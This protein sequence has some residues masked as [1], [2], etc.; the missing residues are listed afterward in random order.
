MINNRFTQYL[1]AELWRA[2]YKARSGKR[3][4]MD[5]HR[6]ELQAALNLD[7][8][9][10]SLLAREYR[11]SRGVAFIIHDPVMRE[12]VAAP[13]RD[14][15]IH[16]FLYNMCAEW[17]D[18]HFIY[19]S[20]SCRIGKGTL[21]GQKRLAHH[22]AAVTQGN[23]RRAFVAKLDIQGY[24]M[25]LNHELLFERVLW[26][27]RQQFYH[28]RD[29]CLTCDPRDRDELY[30]LLKYLWH[31]VIFDEPMKNV[32]TRGRRSNWKGL[33][34]NK[35]LF[36]QPPEQGIVIGN[37]TSQLLSNIFLDQLDRYVTHTLGYK[38][39]GRYVD[40]FYIVVP[41]SQRQ[42]LVQDVD[43]IAKFLESDLK[44]H[45]HPKKRYFQYADRGIPFIGAVVYP[46][47]I[48]PSRR[49]KR[50]FHQAAYRLATQGK[51][52]IESVTARLGGL[53][54]INH[55]RFFKR[56][57][58]TYGWDYGWLSKEAYRQKRGQKN[59]TKSNQEYSQKCGE[60]SPQQK[61]REQKPRDKQPPQSGQGY[62]Q[63]SLW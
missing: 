52:D 46:G 12:I 3:R 15:V 11:P 23:M 20:Y 37:L 1:T 63:L 54:H 36:F 44:L 26:G 47:R 38:H 29:N 53:E 32:T 25:S 49:A 27:L 51:G 31:Q 56:A 55:R 10:Q 33:P 48:L 43:R 60:K 21:F 57:F 62:T 7:I 50:N 6:F 41:E 2:Y 24:F 5:E 18:R 19:D 42:Q 34:R 4:T 40:D 39:Y 9:T 22:I 35:S 45:L 59:S 14:R 30:H 8:L 13:F 16:H 61:L 17:W 58:D 28:S